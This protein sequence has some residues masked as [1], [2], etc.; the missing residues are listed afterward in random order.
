LIS[1]PSSKVMSGPRLKATPDI[2][3]VAKDRMPSLGDREMRPGRRSKS[4]RFGGV[5]RR[6]VGRVA[7][8]SSS[9]LW[10]RPANEPDH[11]AA[12]PVLEAVNK[13]EALRGAA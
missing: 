6:V 4:R 12:T 13:L 9:A 8:T 1:W 7:Q 3:G 10:L 2:R 5:K 11:E